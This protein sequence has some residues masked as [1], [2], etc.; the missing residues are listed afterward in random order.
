MHL[1]SCDQVCKPKTHGGLRIKHVRETNR[2]FMIKNSWGLA[3][4][5]DPFKLN[6]W[7]LNISVVTILCLMFGKVFVMLQRISLRALFGALEMEGM[8]NFG[9]IIGFRVM[10]LLRALLIH[11]SLVDHD[12]AT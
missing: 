2:A 3:T 11:F 6:F 9:E 12:R 10:S 1:V 4:N 5:R 8:L 7:E